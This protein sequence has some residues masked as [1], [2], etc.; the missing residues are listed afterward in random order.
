MYKTQL[1]EFRRIVHTLS[2]AELNE[3]AFN[4][5][6]VLDTLVC[7]SQTLDYEKGLRA[8]AEILIEEVARRVEEE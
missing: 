3:I 6:L 2:K 7:D 1:N 5:V 4:L 8:C